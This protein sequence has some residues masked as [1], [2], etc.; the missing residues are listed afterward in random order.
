MLISAA[1]VQQ[2]PL[3]PGGGMFFMPVGVC[4]IL[5]ALLRRFR[6]MLVWIGI[7]LGVLAITFGANK[8]LRGLPPPSLL[9]V[10]SFVVAIVA[11]AVAF[12]LVIPRVRPTGERQTL[13]ATLAIVGAHFL[14]MI[15]AF[16]VPIAVLGLLCLANGGLAWKLPAYPI[17]AAW[18]VDGALKFAVGMAMWLA[19]PV[20]GY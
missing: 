13:L 3:I 6:M 14:I 7:A 16:G 1:Y 2:F 5:G 12:R 15:P 19:S 18:F 11:E 4:I 20:F 9:Q 8:Y 17:S 10:A